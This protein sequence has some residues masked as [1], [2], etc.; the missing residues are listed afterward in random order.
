MLTVTTRRLD[1]Y[2][3][4]MEPVGCIKI[5][6]EGHEE[7]VLHGAANILRRDHP[8]LIIEIEERHKPGSLAAVRRYLGELGYRGFFFRGGHLRAIE[9]FDLDKQQNVAEIAAKVAGE[10]AYINNF[11]FFAVDALPKVRHLIDAR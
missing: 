1:D 2:A 3:D 4:L 9:S 10:S 7:A 6:V 8:S 11:L 5:D